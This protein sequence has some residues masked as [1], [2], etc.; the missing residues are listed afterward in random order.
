MNKY[1]EG[2]DCAFCGQGEPC[3]YREA[4]RLYNCL[5]EA[6]EVLE[7]YAN[8]TLGELQ[9]DGT[10]KYFIS[11]K[12][13]PTFHATGTT[14]PREILTYDPRPAKEALQKISEVEK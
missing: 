6:K 8:S 12:Q 10:Y 2:I 7:Y 14:Y 4:N 5:Q 11:E 9:D 1:C 13:Q 3:I